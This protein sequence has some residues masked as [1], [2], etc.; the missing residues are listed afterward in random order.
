MEIRIG[1]YECQVRLGEGKSHNLQ[2]FE[3]ARHSN[4][5]HELFV[6]LEGRCH[7]DVEERCVELEAGEALLIPPTRFHCPTY[8]SPELSLLVLPFTVRGTESLLPEEVD[9]TRL[10]LSE[11]SV[12][13]CKKMTDEASG[14][15][16]FKNDALRACGALLLTEVFRLAARLEPERDAGPTGEADKRFALIDNF[17]ET[18]AESG[19]SETELAELVHLSRRQ[20]ARILLSAYGMGFR[21]KLLRSRMDRAGFLLRTTQLPISE[22]AERVGYSSMT[23]FFKAFRHRHSTTPKLYR[24]SFSHTKLGHGDGK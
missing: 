15:A 3:S 4:A 2:R 9:C 13:L 14:S 17:F 5:E 24:E 8:T 19:G 23:A 16:P 20:L 22:I 21:E 12:S 18:A 6:V 11:L 1:K 7:F 10:V